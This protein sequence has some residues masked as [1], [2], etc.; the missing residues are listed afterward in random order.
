[1]KRTLFFL[2]VTVFVVKVYA[3]HGWE[4]VNYTQS[5]IFT[6]IVKIN[7]GWANVGD[8]IGAFVGNECRMIC[9]VRKMDTNDTTFISG[10]LHGEV[11]ETVVFKYWMKSIDFI[12]D[13]DTTV[14][15]NPGADI[16]YFPINLNTFIKSITLSYNEID[17]N[18]QLKVGEEITLKVDVTPSKIYDKSLIWESSNLAVAQV[19]D[20]GIVKAISEGTV[21]IKGTSKDN[22]KASDSIVIVI[23]K[24]PVNSIEVT[25]TYMSDTDVKMDLEVNHGKII[26]VNVL[27]V[28]ASNKK[29]IITSSNPSVVEVNGNNIIGKSVGEAIITVIS[30]DNNTIKQ[31]IIISVF[32][33]QT[34]VSINNLAATISVFPIPARGYITI[35]SDEIIQ[36]IIIQDIKGCRIKYFG[37]VNTN[38]IKVS[39]SELKNGIYYIKIN[40]N[41]TIQ[42]IKE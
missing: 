23:K 7:G 13:I 15:S 42:F 19:N 11:K 30:E 6:G 31:S 24:V 10:V 22:N 12:Y 20:K 40:S 1:M 28:D 29:F 41:K 27:P 16:H 34:S 2:L 21:V 18:I 37:F 8:V 35:N 4:R 5:T 26:E 17:D 39:I 38:S 14:I 36:D 33:S 25:G 32:A 9:E 3:G